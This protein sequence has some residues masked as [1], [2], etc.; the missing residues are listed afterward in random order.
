MPVGAWIAFFQWFWALAPGRY[1]CLCCKSIQTMVK[2]RF[3]CAIGARHVAIVQG[4]PFFQTK[5][6]KALSPRDAT[7]VITILVYVHD[8]ARPGGAK[9]SAPPPAPRGTTK[10]RTREVLRRAGRRHRP[11]SAAQNKAARTTG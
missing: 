6:F 5:I 11:P 2:T 8:P 9:A 10:R 7:L 1:V 4:N 3:R